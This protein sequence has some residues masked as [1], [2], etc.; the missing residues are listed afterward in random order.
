MMMQQQEVR[1]KG[2]RWTEA[3]PKWWK[4]PRRGG[5]NGNEER[6]KKIEVH[7]AQWIG[8]EHREN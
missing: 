8:T 7:L 5:Q 1:I 6:S 3:I 4:Q 2:S